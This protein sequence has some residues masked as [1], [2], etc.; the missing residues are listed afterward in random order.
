MEAVS[1][2]EKSSRTIISRLSYVWFMADKRHFSI[3]LPSSR[4]G[5]SIDTTS[6]LLLLDKGKFNLKPTFN[7]GAVS[8]LYKV[9]KSKEANTVEPPQKN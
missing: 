9:I 7:L 8:K 3:L 5:I 6:L 1:S 2:L 4:A